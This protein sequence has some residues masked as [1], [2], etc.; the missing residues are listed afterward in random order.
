MRCKLLEEGLL[1]WSGMN[2]LAWLAS[3]STTVLGGGMNTWIGFWTGRGVSEVADCTDIMK[4]VK[5]R[6]FLITLI[7]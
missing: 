4:N 5:P 1:R 7:R 3:W 2:W 6:L